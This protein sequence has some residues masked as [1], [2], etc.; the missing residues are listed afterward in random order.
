MK[1][2]VVKYAKTGLYR[3]YFENAPK[4]YGEG[5]TQEDATR[6]LIEKM[7]AVLEAYANIIKER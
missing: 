6:E 2:I 1:L 4:L 7:Y 5:N 3:A